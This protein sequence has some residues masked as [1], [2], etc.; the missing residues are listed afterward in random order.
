[1]LSVNGNTAVPPASAQ[2]D[3][4]GGD[5]IKVGFLR[6]SRYFT[7]RSGEDGSGGRDIKY[8]PLVCVL[9]GVGVGWY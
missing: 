6:I 8:R 1:M 9:W 3:V 5:Y 4:S 2:G 7:D